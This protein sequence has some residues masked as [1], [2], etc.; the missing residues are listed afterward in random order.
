MLTTTGFHPRFLPGE[1]AYLGYEIVEGACEEHPA[2]LM[3]NKGE[4]VLVLEVYNRSNGVSYSVEGPTN[5]GKP[6]Y[7]YDRDLMA[8]KPI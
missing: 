1:Y 5:P 4:K 7:A 3:G 2:Y 8:T 6:W